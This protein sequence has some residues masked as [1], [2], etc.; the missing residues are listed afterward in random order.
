MNKTAFFGSDELAA[1]MMLTSHPTAPLPAE[2]N[3]A[4]SKLYPAGAAPTVADLLAGGWLVYSVDKRRLR[5]APP[6]PSEYWQDSGAST[7][8]VMRP[9]ATALPVVREPERITDYSTTWSADNALPGLLNEPSQLVSYFTGPITNTAPRASI[10]LQQ[11][12]A[13]LTSPPAYLRRRAHAAQTEYEVH[14]KSSRYKRLKC[15][16][17]YFTAG[18]TFTYRRDDALLIASGLL[19][20][21]FDKLEG[22]V[23]E[24]RTA[25]LTDAA[26]APALALMFTSPSGDGLKVVMAADPRFSRHTNYEY[27]ARHLASRYGWGIT[28][29]RHTADISRACFL[30][31]DPTAWLAP[32][33]AT[34]SGIINMPR[35]SIGS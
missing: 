5:L 19:V 27:L 13:V 28:L 22:Q 23:T 32:A 35:Q 4:L 18:G 20:L 6:A 10:T 3:E 12:H 24:V 14:G 25:L 33:Y 17:D 31:Y 11:L 1:A 30:S 21:D 9:N 16:L 8:L 29:D 2:L 26:L 15:D 7:R 34:A